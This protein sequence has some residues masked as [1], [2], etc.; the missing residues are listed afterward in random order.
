MDREL[1]AVLILVD[2]AFNFDEVVLLEGIERI[3]DVVP[4]FGFDVATAV[5]K[6]QRQIWFPGLLGFDLLGDDNEAR[7]DDFVLV[8]A[9]VAEVKV[10]HSVII[11]ARAGS[12]ALLVLKNQWFTPSLS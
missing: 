4:H 6:R 1:E 12:Q 10:L 2:Q 11:G 7:D 5:A 3:F 8:P 9:A